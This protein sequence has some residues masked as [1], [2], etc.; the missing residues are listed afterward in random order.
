[1][2]FLINKVLLN[3]GV[4]MPIG[5][6]FVFLGFFSLTELPSAQSQLRQFEKL[7]QMAAA[8]SGQ[9]AFIEGVII[10][11]NQ[12][13][14]RQF[15]AYLREEYR[16]SG[17]TSRMAE[18]A[19][20]TPPLLIESNGQTIRVSNNDYVLEKT[21]FTVEEAPPTFSKGAVQTRG[22]VIGSPVLTV[23]TVSENGKEFVAEFLYAGT[24]AEFIAYLNRQVH[25]G[26]WYGSSFLL[27]GALMTILGV[28]LS[29]SFLRECIGDSIII[30]G[31]RKILYYRARKIRKRNLLAQKRNNEQISR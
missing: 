20:H 27:V 14:H 24:R 19:R 2:R 7:L 1:M 28:G 17:R 18:V 22:F 12:T 16:S 23:G 13:V 10:N 30:L 29:W 9:T 3:P 8:T 15:T 4:L 26:L 6:L 5:L 21:D 25:F 31:V 11:R